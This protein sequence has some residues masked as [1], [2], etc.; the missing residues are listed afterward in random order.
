MKT[1]HMLVCAVSLL[2]ITGFSEAGEIAFSFGSPPLASVG[3]GVKNELAT[4]VAVPMPKLML[5]LAPMPKSEVSANGSKLTLAVPSSPPA[6]NTLSF[7]DKEILE[8][9]ARIPFP[10]LHYVHRNWRLWNGPEGEDSFGRLW[11]LPKGELVFPY[12]KWEYPTRKEERVL[13]GVFWTKKF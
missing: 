13:V 2:I 12:F 10:N 7:L 4:R 3:V 1:L 6:T 9:P 5:A 8:V 11:K